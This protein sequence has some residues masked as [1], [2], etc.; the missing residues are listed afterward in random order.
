MDTH[1]VIKILHL[2]QGLSLEEIDNYMRMLAGIRAFVERY[3]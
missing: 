3:V 1:H 2:A